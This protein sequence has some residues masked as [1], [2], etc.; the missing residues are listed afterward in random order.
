VFS[1]QGWSLFSGSS[2]SGG[3]IYSY[4]TVNHWVPIIGRVLRGPCTEPSRICIILQHLKLQSNTIRTMP[5]HRI[6]R[7]PCWTSWTQHS[8]YC[9]QYV[10]RTSC[11]AVL[12]SITLH[13]HC[14]SASFH[15]SLE[16]QHYV[17]TVFRTAILLQS[18]MI[19]TDHWPGPGAD[20]G[21]QA[22]PGQC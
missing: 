22:R 11:A 5:P 19:A 16:L 21:S 7:I 3:H 17:Q 18:L 10:Q 4:I 1:G 2:C 13:V 14:T 15:A 20:T 6:H 9:W 12:R 8:G